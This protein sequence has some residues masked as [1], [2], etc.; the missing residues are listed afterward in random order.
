MQRGLRSD[1]D[2]LVTDSFSMYEVRISIYNL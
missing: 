1:P 2:R